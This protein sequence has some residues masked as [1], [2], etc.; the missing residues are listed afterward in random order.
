MRSKYDPA[1]AY[2]DTY[3]GLDDD[4]WCSCKHLRTSHDESGKCIACN[5]TEAE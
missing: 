5:C 3:H 4:E 1:E 2:M